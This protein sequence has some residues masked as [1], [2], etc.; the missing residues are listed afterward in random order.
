MLP[1]QLCAV[2]LV[3][4]LVAAQPQVRPA[5]TL[6]WPGAG[7]W[8]EL[9][10]CAQ[11][12]HTIEFVL[13]AVSNTASYLRLWALSLAHS[14]LSAVFYERVM[15]AGLQAQTTFPYKCLYLFIG[16]HRLPWACRRH[17]ACRVRWH[18]GPRLAAMLPQHKLGWGSL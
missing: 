8:A 6:L 4:L 13:G 16:A 7:V 12:I 1:L 11:M 15:L 18:C 2:Q 10:P 3:C 5:C 17:S 9:C 14:Q